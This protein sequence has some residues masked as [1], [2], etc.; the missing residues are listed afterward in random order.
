M[1]IALALLVPLL[2][3]VLASRLGAPARLGRRLAPFAPL[4]LLLPWLRGE[5]V[6]WS[7]AVLGVDLGV[8]PWVAPFV[9][10]TALAWSL[11]GWFAVDRVTGD[12][13]RFWLGWWSSLFGMILV[14]LAQS[15]VAFYLGYVTV[16]LAAYL[17]IVHA[18][19]EAA[20][21][22]GRVYLVL[23][24]AGEAA[25]VTGVLLLAG[26][27]GNVEL[28]L[29]ATEPFVAGLEA[30]RWWLL[31]G[32]ALKLGIVP[33]HVWLPLAHP[34]AP[35]PAS[36]VLSGVIVKAG[37]LGWLKLAPVGGL[38]VS[39][40]APWL[41][42][43]GLTT[44]F[45]GAGVGLTQRGLKTVLAYSTVS[46]MGLV[47]V[48][49][50][51][52]TLQP[53][54]D[55]RW[56]GALGLLALHHGLNKG[57]LFLACGCAP[58]STP[59]RRALLALSA[60]ALAAAP[61]TSGYLAKTWLKRAVDAG[62]ELGALP[63]VAYPLVTLTSAATALL[64][65][66]L[67]RAALAERDASAPLHPAWPL[68]A[69]LGLIAPW[70][71]AWA[72]GAVVVPSASGSW[73]AVWPLLVALSLIVAA[74]W[75]VRLGGW[76][77]LELPPGDLVVLGERAIAAMRRAPAV[78]APAWVRSRRRRGWRGAVG[79]AVATV[80]RSLRDVST[81]GLLTLLV[82]VAVWAALRA[83]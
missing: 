54:D 9:L 74:R 10:L 72:G 65:W 70:A 31:A 66:R 36:A 19:D 23:A 80:E 57:A 24:F 62:I 61:L 13:R 77:G 18:A 83:T 33:L 44:A 59:F 63:G 27:Y 78:A 68:L 25:I 52:L 69:V 17:T 3:A 56:I 48:G 46:Q 82:A 35:V 40:S 15:L 55:G 49:Y 34:I 22:A 50:A 6:S 28:A 71:W 37:L 53:G 12:T 4:L 1:T 43:L 58:G 11:A 8:D 47:L 20:R 14:V 64:L 75:W 30:S 29:L 67:W 32:F 42:A 39:A 73:D 81:A 38:D 26:A 5:R 51:A 16:S 79:R 76:S 45:V 41:V 7:W 60:A 2:G 21:R